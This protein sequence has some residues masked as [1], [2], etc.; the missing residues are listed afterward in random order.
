MVHIHFGQD[1]LAQPD[2]LKA[3]ELAQDAIEG[4]LQPRFVAQQVIELRRERNV[5]PKR[6]QL[7]SLD[8]IEARAVM[9]AVFV[10]FLQVLLHDKMRC[11]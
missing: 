10:A 11:H 9:L 8:S 3:F 5:L 2:Q 6:F 1:R 7:H 4:P